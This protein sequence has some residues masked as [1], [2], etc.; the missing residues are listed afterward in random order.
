[1]W[2]KIDRAES[3]YAP[4][5]VF[6]NAEQLDIICIRTILA[7]PILRAARHCVIRYAKPSTLHEALALLGD[8]RWKIL[9]GGTDFYPALGSKPLS[10]NVLDINGLVE[11]AGISQTASH[12]EIGARTTWTDLI[13]H[14]LPAAF[15]ALKEAAKEVGSVQIQNVASVAGNLCNASPAA[16]GVPA[17][18][19]LDAEVELKSAGGTRTLALGAFI[20]GNRKTALRQEEI[21]TAIRVPKTSATGTSSFQKLGARRY[22]VISIA[23]AA[24]RVVLGGDGRV[25][26]A[27][28]AVGS[29]SAVAQRLSGL[30]TTLLGLKSGKEIAGAVEAASFDELVPI[31]DVRGSAEYR[32]SA[33]REIALR[34]LNGALGHANAGIAA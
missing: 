34:A 21:V 23:M 29:C 26:N 17:L 31:D 30:E 20:L 24:A 33:A 14:P 28:I 7:G 13:R 5:V 4:K 6:D 9:A 11:L 22:L 2:A 1:M 10:E 18:M 25:S 8:A 27:A 19:A 12:I 15:Y 32:H 16:D 3:D